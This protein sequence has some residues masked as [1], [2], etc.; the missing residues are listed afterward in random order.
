MQDRKFRFC[1]LTCLLIGAAALYGAIGNGAPAQPRWPDEGGVFAADGWRAGA[2]SIEFANGAVF[3]SRPFRHNDSTT[4]NLTIVT[5]TNSKLFGAGAD[6]PFLGNGYTVHAT[7]PEL[8]EKDHGAAGLIAEQGNEHWLVLYAYG[9]RRGLLGNGV[10]GWTMALLDG[11]LGRANDYYKLYLITS[12][13]PDTAG[14]RE[15]V[16]LAQTLF[17]RISAWY[18]S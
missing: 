10:Q 8:I 11:V 15:S 2:A 12:A 7:P 18:A 1:F 3:L 14:A 9:E 13:A 5:M 17:P 6:L 16:E 4:A